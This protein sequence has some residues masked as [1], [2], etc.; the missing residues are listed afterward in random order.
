M[1]SEEV[2]PCLHW[3]YGIT[4]SPYTDWSCVVVG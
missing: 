2:L 1:L 4:Q 3:W